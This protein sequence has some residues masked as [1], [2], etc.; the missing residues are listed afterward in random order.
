MTELLH[1]YINGN[2]I[3]S[4]YDN[5]TKISKTISKDSEYL[6]YDFPESFDFK[7][8]NKCNG[9]CGFCHENSTSNGGN[10]PLKRFL[11]SRF[12]TS[13]HPFTEMAIGGGNVFE[14]EDLKLL[15][16]ENKTKNI[17]SSITVSQKHLKE[18]FHQLQELVSDNLIKGLGISIVNPQDLETISLAKSLGN[19]IVFHVINGLVDETWENVFSNNKVLILGFKRKGRGIQYLSD[20]PSPIMRNQAWL[21]KNLKRLSG[22]SEILSFDCLAVKQ[23][24]PKKNLDLSCNEWEMLYDGD[25]EIPKD[26]LGNIRCSTMFVD[27]PKRKIARSSISSTRY[28][29]DLKETIETNFRRTFQ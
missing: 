2:H 14:S 6:T 12:Y 13:I 9:G 26:I 23:L 8:T 4:I 22:I 5:G 21:E 15:L 16:Q 27:F 19:N 3:V 20:N 18:N 25:D 28:D 7:L 24:N 11:S 29:L 10:P 1:S 17:L